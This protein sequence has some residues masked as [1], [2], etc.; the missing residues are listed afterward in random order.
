MLIL[1]SM[2]KALVILDLNCVLYTKNL[3]QSDT[4]HA[5]AYSSAEGNKKSLDHL[6][7]ILLFKS[8]LFF[9]NNN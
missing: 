9:I 5:R 6:F 8:V 1:I 7:I 3:I 2:S 4:P